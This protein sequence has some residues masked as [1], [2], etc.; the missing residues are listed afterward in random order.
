MM[1]RKARLHTGVCMPWRLC[2][3]A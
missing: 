3:L 1:R 2:M